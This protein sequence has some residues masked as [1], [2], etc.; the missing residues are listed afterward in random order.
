MI[1][2]KINQE[3]FAYDI[4]SLIKAFYPEEEVNVREKPEF[5]EE[6]PLQMAASTGNEE[7]EFAVYEN[8][9]LQKKSRVCVENPERK[10]VKN[11]LKRLIYGVLSEYTGR[12]L[13]WGTL[14]GIRPVKIPMAMLEQGRSNVEIADY[15][16]STY[17]CSNEK[18]A[19][20]V[21]IA[22]RE[23]EVL[24]A[25]DYREGY[26]LYVGIPFCPSICLYC[27]FSS[28]PIKRW[29][30]QV[31][32]YLEAL[33]L[34][35]RFLGKAYKDRKLNTIYVG[36]GTPTTLTEEQL[37]RLLCVLEE[38]FDYSHLRELTVEAGRPDSVTLEKFRVLKE[39]GVTRVS[40]NPQTM[41]QETLD[42]IGRRH[43]AE[44]TKEAFFMARE[45]GF[46]NINMDL[47]VGLPGEELPQVCHTL[48][49]LRLLG[50]DSITVHSLAVKRAARLKLFQ[51]EYREMGLTNSQEI[52]DSAYRSC[53]ER[54]LYPYYL[55]RQKNMTGNFEN[56]GYAKVD[57]AGIYNIL[58][59]E[60][61]Q[62]IVACGAGSVS[63]RVYPDGRIERCEN[64]KDVAL[65]I[66]KIDEMIERKRKLLMD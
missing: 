33:F 11:Q 18:T 5:T 59:M 27:S 26:S 49:E 64:V 1:E 22:N 16:R 54:G 25:I 52:M 34:E 24:R 42:I 21:S 19:L 41:N 8:G 50:P 46:D 13:P 51:E 6:T 48:E 30:K 37:H 38:S 14:T 12:K 15:M 44:Q 4:H 39:H 36:G 17:L 55:Y 56:V 60:E 65:Y 63:K 32:A 9:A 57:K 35:L 43:T 10:L 40:V 61:K 53:V 31:D 45:A 29:E 62:S 28:S 47:I 3:S 66:E 7:I 2:V 20:A 58:I 23:R